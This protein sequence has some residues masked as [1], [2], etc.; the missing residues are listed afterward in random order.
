MSI[1]HHLAFDPSD[2]EKKLHKRNF[3]NSSA[4]GNPLPTQ[5]DMQYVSYVERVGG[6][7]SC[8]ITAYRDI[9]T[10]HNQ[11][12]QGKTHKALE[13]HEVGNTARTS[14]IATLQSDYSGSSWRSNWRGGEDVC[15]LVNDWWNTINVCNSILITSNRWLYNAMNWK[16]IDKSDRWIRHRWLYSLSWEITFLVPK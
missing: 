4:V 3:K 12:L 2:R 11:W 13:M 6:S 8:R 1:W 14:K 16:P 9:I 5:A 15:V 10:M 7:S